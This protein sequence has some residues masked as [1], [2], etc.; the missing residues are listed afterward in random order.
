[1][2]VQ[3]YS[4]CWCNMQYMLHWHKFDDIVLFILFLF[5]MSTY[6]YLE[7]KVTLDIA[8]HFDGTRWP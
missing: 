8:A 3:Q 7:I 2:L 6:T 4:L 1:M 5:V